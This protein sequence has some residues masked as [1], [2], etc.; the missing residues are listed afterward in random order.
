MLELFGSGLLGTIFGGIFRLFPE[1]LKFFDKKNERTH[2]L[3]MFKEQ[4]ELEKTRGDIKLQEIG[5]QREASN[6][7]GSLTAF[8]AAITQQTE[9][10]KA[11]GPGWVASLSASVRPIVTY[12]I[13]GIWAFIHLNTA[14]STGIGVEAVF[15][16]VMTPDFTALVSGTLNYWFLDRTLSKRGL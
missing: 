15:K 8:N 13:L 6:D 14:L 7:I 2:E 3:A 5:A 1:V 12:L 9:M 16:L 11:A 4:T 10:V